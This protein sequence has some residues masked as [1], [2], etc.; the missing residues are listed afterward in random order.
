MM[1]LIR[2]ADCGR[3]SR[4]SFFAASMNSGSLTI[5]SNA[6]RSA[7]TRSAG[8]PGVVANGRPTVE[9]ARHELQQRLVLRLDRQIENQRDIRQRGLLFDA[10]P[11]PAG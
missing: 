5:V 1:S 10:R 7:A 9:A 4:S 6:W 11:E 3:T 8:T 2:S